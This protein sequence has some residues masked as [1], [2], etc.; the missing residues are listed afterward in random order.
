MSLSGYLNTFDNHPFLVDEKNKLQIQSTLKT[1][2][3]TQRRE[4]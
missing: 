1:V 3:F 4:I 2:C